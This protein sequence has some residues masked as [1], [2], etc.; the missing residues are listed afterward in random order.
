[1]SANEML[2]NWWCDG[3]DGN[4]IKCQE[5]RI[6]EGQLSINSDVRLIDFLYRSPAILANMMIAASMRRDEFVLTSPAGTFKDIDDATAKTVEWLMQP[7][8][9]DT[10][11]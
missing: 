3:C 4:V 11:E 2:Q 1:M 8:G 10:N 9:G 6:C 7:Y 5:S